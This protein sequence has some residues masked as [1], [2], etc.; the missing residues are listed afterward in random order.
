MKRPYIDSSIDHISSQAVKESTAKLIDEG[1]VLFVVRGMILAHSFP[2]AICKLPVTVNQDMK[3]LTL[4]IPIMNEFVLRAMM[5]LKP[6][7]LAKV[8]R[9]SHGT[10]RIESDAYENILFPVPPLSEQERIVAKVDELMALCHLVETHI[11]TAQ[12]EGHQLLESIL[13]TALISDR[14]TVELQWNT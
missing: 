1:S 13:R 8:L 10:C 6:I 3:T 14:P 11:E 7:I 5:G 9:S 2:V 12:T 4:H